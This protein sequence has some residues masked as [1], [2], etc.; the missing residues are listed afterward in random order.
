SPRSPAVW[1]SSSAGSGT[2]GGEGRPA[3]AAAAYPLRAL[4]SAS[5]GVRVPWR[6]ND[7][8]RSSEEGNEEGPFRQHRVLRRLKLHAQGGQS[9]RGDREGVRREVEADRGL[10]RR[11]RCQGRREAHLLEEG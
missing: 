4:I 10:G 1:R 8:E 11:V 5:S 2:P 6:W 7:E 9:G 3:G